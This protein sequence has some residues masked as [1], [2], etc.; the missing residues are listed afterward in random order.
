M[1]ANLFLK[2]Q[3]SLSV[4]GGPCGDNQ[5]GRTEFGIH[6]CMPC[7]RN[8]RKHML[9]AAEFLL[10][11]RPGAGHGQ[12]LQVHLDLCIRRHNLI[13]DRSLQKGH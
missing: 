9:P 5:P 1:D 13:H 11:D 4:A 8:S 12:L 2:Q 6:A 3:Y 10:L 7:Q